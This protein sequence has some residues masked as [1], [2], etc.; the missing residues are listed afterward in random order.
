[1]IKNTKYVLLRITPCQGQ[2]LSS[3]K[4]QQL[5]EHL[6]KQ[7]QEEIKISLVEILEKFPIHNEKSIMQQSSTP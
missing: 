1:M 7:S 6:T 2:E 5:F 3:E 4:V